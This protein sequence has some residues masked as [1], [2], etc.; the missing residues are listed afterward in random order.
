M[1]I[2][3]IPDDGGHDVIDNFEFPCNSKSNFS[4][5][6]HLYSH[7]ECKIIGRASHE[8]T[9]L[10]LQAG[11]MHDLITLKGYSLKTM[12]S[13]SIKVYIYSERV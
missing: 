1:T 8:Q 13:S 7:E 10:H 3:T 2:N 4:L 6:L 11:K 9:L 5:K 12:H